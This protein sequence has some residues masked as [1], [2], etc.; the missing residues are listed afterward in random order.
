MCLQEMY[1]I[2][3]GNMLARNYQEVCEQIYFQLIVMIC[4]QKT[5]EES[6]F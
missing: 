5:L 2:P 4:K 3:E 6:A 1:I